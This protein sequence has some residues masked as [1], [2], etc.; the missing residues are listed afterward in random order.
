MLS[1]LGSKL[2][3][4]DQN[5]QSNTIKTFS[6]RIKTFS[7]TIKT[8]RAQLQRLQL[9]QSRSPFALDLPH[10][11]STPG[12]VLLCWYIDIDIDVSLMLYWYWSHTVYPRKDSFSYWFIDIDMDTLPQWYWSPAPT[13]YPRKGSLDEID[14]NCLLILILIS[15]PLF[16]GKGS[17]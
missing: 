12:K 16:T 4:E 15:L 11:L 5:F 7:L 3:F 2:S 13:V 8:F 14:E 10:P 9:F 17:M 1:V 6:L